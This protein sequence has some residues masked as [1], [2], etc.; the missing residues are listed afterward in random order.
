MAAADELDNSA[1]VRTQLIRMKRGGHPPQPVDML[2][3]T[4]ER[5][6]ESHQ[7][8]EPHDEPL[9]EADEPEPDIDAMVRN[10][11]AVAEEQ[12]LTQAP[13]HAAEQ[14]PAGGVRALRRP[15]NPYSPANQPRHLMGER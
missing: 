6:P 11:L 9:P 12:G 2:R 8:H 14:V 7:A 10:S 3:H 15:P 13:P 1:W 4:Q 5:I